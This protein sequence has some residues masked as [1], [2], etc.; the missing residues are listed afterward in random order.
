MVNKPL[1]DKIEKLSE[2]YPDVIFV[3]MCEVADY[4]QQQVQKKDL[5]QV[6]DEVVATNDVYQ[7]PDNGLV[8]FVPKKG[9]SKMEAYESLSKLK[10]FG[11]VLS[12]TA[13]QQSGA[14]LFY[15]DPKAE[16]AQNAKIIS[17]LAKA[18]NRKE[19]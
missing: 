4:M 2:L 5:P 19:K 6:L 7:N 15:A 17:G 13:E 11:L 9:V 3:R 1:Y 16:G 18:L 8:G 14:R 12:L 10:A